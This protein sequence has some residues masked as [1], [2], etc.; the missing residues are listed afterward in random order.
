[1]LRQP[2]HSSYSS[3]DTASPTS[4]VHNH[5]ED[6]GRICKAQ[7]EKRSVSQWARQNIVIAFLLYVAKNVRTFLWTLV[8]SPASIVT[9][10]LS[11]TATLVV[12]PVVTTILLGAVV[13]LYL[14]SLL[15]GKR[16]V[17][18]LSN[19]YAGGWS[20]VNWAD[21]TIFGPRSLMAIK[22]AR[23]TL[24]GQV[25]TTV[26]QQAALEDASPDFTAMKTVRVFSLPLARTLLLM[27]AIVYERDDSL[28]DDAA[29]VVMRAQERYA[30]GSP[31]YA[32]EMQRAEDLIGRSE[33]LIK[34]K[35]AE[36]GLEFDGVSDLT[37]VGGPFASIFYT[38]VGSDKPFICLVFKGTTPT[39][40]QEFLTDATI[41]K[42]TASVFFGPGSGGCHE[43]FYS[44]LFRR[45]DSGEGGG[46]DGY[47]SIVRSLRHVAARMKQA[48]GGG[49]KIPLWVAGHSLGSALASLCFARFLRSESDLG[50]D[51]ELRDCYSY[52]TPRLGDGNFASAFEQTL[53]TPLDRKNILWRVRN[54]LDIVTAVPPGLGDNE[55]MRSALASASVLNYAWLGAAVRLRPGTLPYRAPFYVLERL[56]AFHEAVDVQVVDVQAESV[57]TESKVVDE[58][59]KLK[60]KYSELN[61]LAALLALVPAPLYNHFPASY[62]DHL[63]TIYTTVQQHAAARIER[64]QH[65]FG[66]V[67][68]GEHAAE[69]AAEF[70]ESS[71]AKLKSVRE[72][73]GG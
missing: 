2:A 4:P 16:V 1:M 3:S 53:V 38:P 42:T 13:G 73:Y 62:L 34:D 24:S 33:K 8:V 5:L 65:P 14:F 55:S 72:K 29:H 46:G 63:D 36:W 23:G 32:G 10:P 12:Y 25:E 45:N 61:P 15:G 21:P 43:G 37:T 40:F 44:N 35:A 56:G 9:D 26:V 71:L 58:A 41:N 6:L 30:V 19:R 27:S 54:H 68:A 20:V 64:A 50:P 22:D 49:D 67:G 47:G 70:A 69:K 52:G 59:A 18:W 51:L 17:D 7:R 28:I 11:T 39:R 31:E 57:A 48:K 66:G 60:A